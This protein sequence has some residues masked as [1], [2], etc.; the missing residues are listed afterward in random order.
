MR[1]A[2]GAADDD[3]YGRPL[4]NIELMRRIRDA[5]DPDHICNSSRLPL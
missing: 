5:F 4:P 2:G 3:G 1:E